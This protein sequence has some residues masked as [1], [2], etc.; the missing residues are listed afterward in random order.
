MNEKSLSGSDPRHLREKGP[1]I[2]GRNSCQAPVSRI[3][4]IP[5]GIQVG[6]VAHI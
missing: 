6:R 1:A 4:G 3:Y 2:I 5:N